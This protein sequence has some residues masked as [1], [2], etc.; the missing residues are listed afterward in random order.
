MPDI[1]TITA[2]FSSIKTATD[3]VKFLR[4]SDLSLERAELK[5]KL[6]DLV[7]ALADTKMQL[8]ELQDMIVDKDKRINEMEDAF[9]TKDKIVRHN[10]AYYSLDDTGNPV[11]VPFCLRCWEVEHKKR[12]LVRDS[13]NGS[14]KICT[15]CRHRYDGRSTIDIINKQ[16]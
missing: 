9:Q 13:E 15:A 16:V 5:L 14:K 1:S 8:V 12:Q 11:G 4:E 6:A 2:A 3:I 7:S 10:D